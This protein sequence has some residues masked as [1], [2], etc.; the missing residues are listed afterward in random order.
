M[1][2]VNGTNDAIKRIGGVW[3]FV[4][5]RSVITNRRFVDAAIALVKS[6]FVADT[7]KRQLMDMVFS[8]YAERP[9]EWGVK[10]ASCSTSDGLLIGEFIPLTMTCR[11]RTAKHV[12]CNDEMTKSLETLTRDGLEQYAGRDIPGAA[13]CTFPRSGFKKRSATAARLREMPSYSRKEYTGVFRRAVETQ[14]REVADNWMVDNPNVLHPRVAF[15]AV[16]EV[17]HDDA[18]F[19]EIQRQ[20]L[21]AENIQ[22]EMVP[23]VGSG[24]KLKFADYSFE[25]RWTTFHRDRAKLQVLTKQEHRKK[26]ALE[27]SR[28]GRERRSQPIT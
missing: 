20:F 21:E 17:D 4:Y 6:F 28:H 14:K 26:T 13:R 2:L 25:Q 24:R 19:S 12:Q 22:L 16:Y 11:L 3:Q 1:L 5:S 7:G 8:D 10:L 18:R 9:A 27:N 15:S 23:L